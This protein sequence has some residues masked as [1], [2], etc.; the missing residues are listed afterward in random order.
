MNYFK[1]NP[2][3]LNYTMFKDTNLILKNCNKLVKVKREFKKH[4]AIDNK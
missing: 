1:L 3:T 2:L 4:S